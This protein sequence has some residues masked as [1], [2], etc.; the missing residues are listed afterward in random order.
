MLA[1]AEL[2][3]CHVLLIGL[4]LIAQLVVKEAA[5]ELGIA[6]LRIDCEG[7][8]VSCALIIVMSDGLCMS[9]EHA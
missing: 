2:K 9:P 4:G 5:E 8:L 7:F 3:E 1:Q 6:L